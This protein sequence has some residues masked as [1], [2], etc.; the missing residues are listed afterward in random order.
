MLIYD[1]PYW[2]E[3]FN[4]EINNNC[5]SFVIKNKLILYKENNFTENKKLFRFSVLIEQDI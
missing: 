5:E 4:I 1:I 3:F 2:W